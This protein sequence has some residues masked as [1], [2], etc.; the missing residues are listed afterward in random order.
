M[1]DALAIGASP[2]HASAGAWTRFG[3]LAAGIG[4]VGTQDERIAVEFANR[5]SPRTDSFSRAVSPFGTYV[6]IALS[7]GLLGEGLLFHDPR[8]RDMGRDA[9]EAEIFAA[10]IATP[11]LKGLVGRAR[12]NRGGDSD[13]FHPLS[14]DLSF[15]SGHVAEAFAVASVVAARSRGW[16]VPTAAYA[17]ASGVALAR[18]NDRAHFASDVLAGALV[19]TAIGRA[20]VRRH[21]G[22]EERRVSWSLLPLA[23]RK[24]AGIAVAI[25]TGGRRAR[26]ESRG[27][28]LPESP[29]ST[30]GRTGS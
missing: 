19:G 2:F 28:G 22:A 27:G 26:P 17:L 13:E 24:G 4:I 11:I 8:V 16:V 7:A 5:R 29:E 30:G 21:A 23:S 12:P 1:D 6:P 10:G 18:M 25:S 15:P 14:N 9:I 20:V 3:V